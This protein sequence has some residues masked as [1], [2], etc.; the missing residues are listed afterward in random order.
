MTRKSLSFYTPEQAIITVA[1][2]SLNLT[3][4]ENNIQECRLRMSI[5]PQLYQQIQE[6]Q[7]FNLKPELKEL[8][9]TSTF[10]PDIN[11]DLEI[12]LHPDF[13]AYLWEQAQDRETAINYL[14]S[15]SSEIQAN[16]ELE[17]QLNPLLNTD[18]WLCLSVQQT[19]EME[20]V[21][22]KTFW[23]YLNL[24]KLNQPENIEQEIADNILNFVRDWTEENLTEITKQATQE[25][26]NL[27]DTFLT[28][29]DNDFTVN[30]I[31][32]DV[33]DFFESEEWSFVKFPEKSI[34]RLLFHGEKGKFTCY[35]KVKEKQ[36]QFIFYSLCPVDIPESKRL[37][38]AELITRI[39]CENIIGNFDLD[40]EQGNLRYK[41][42]ICLGDEYLSD[43]LLKPLVYGNVKMM[44]K[45]LPAIMAVVEKNKTPLEAINKSKSV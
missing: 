28:L 3:V 13:M 36:R 16:K 8:G 30:D 1:E 40:F 12:I 22:Y 9:N 2:F 27:F 4:E 44:D 17:G 6:K 45:Y 10:L 15:S 42:S 32:E 35:A 33:I 19:Q 14:I 39:N 37:V 21:G 31:L 25:I 29:E 26:D 7:L 23:S 34:L 11:L 18:N 5:T 38:I 41:T 20:I 43:D 24:T